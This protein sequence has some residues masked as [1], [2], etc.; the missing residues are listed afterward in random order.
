M[1]KKKTAKFLADCLAH[2]PD[3]PE[4]VQRVVNTTV[5]GLKLIADG[6]EWPENEALAAC[7]DAWDSTCAAARAVRAATWAARAEARAATSVA[8]AAAKSAAEWAARATTW[9]AVWAAV[10]HPDPAKERARQAKVRK[11]LGL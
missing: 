7:A 11:E 5:A 10:S 6:G 3:Q 9:A 8:R 1:S 4:Q 2:M